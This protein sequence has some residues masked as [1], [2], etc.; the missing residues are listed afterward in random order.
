ML[1]GSRKNKRVE[2][3]EDLTEED[4]KEARE[5]DMDKEEDMV[6]VEAYHLP[7]LIV[8]K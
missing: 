1:S 8:V 4:T 6:V 2:I 7:T 3:A 5:E